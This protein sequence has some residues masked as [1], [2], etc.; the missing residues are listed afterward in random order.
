MQLL[1]IVIAIITSETLCAQTPSDGL[2]MPSKNIC[3]LF[4]YDM[5]T[6]DR[7]WEGS[8]LRSNE[9][10]AT[11][12]RN[13]VLPM[14]AIGILD[15]LNF[16]VSLPFISTESSEPNGGKFAG[17]RGFQDIGFALK[18]RPIRKE[19]G[20]GRI[21]FLGTAGFSTPFTIRQKWDRCTAQDFFSRLVEC[22]N[23]LETPACKLT[24]VVSE[25]LAELDDLPGRRL[26]R[27]SGA[28]ATCFALFDD[29]ATARSAAQILLARQQNWWVRAS[30]IRKARS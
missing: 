14:A 28:G 5:G 20:P 9:T 8:Y 12:D 18:Y 1:G 15:N 26:V 11:V 21:S 25:V 16:Y 2:M 13:M 30:L 22:Q 29:L 6:F 27:M 23:D 3:V 7:Y 17:A 10:I 4:S 19:L 24:P